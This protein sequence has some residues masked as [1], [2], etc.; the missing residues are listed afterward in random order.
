MLAVAMFFRTIM[1]A[2]SL[3]M[4][5]YV[6]RKFFNPLNTFKTAMWFVLVGYCIMREELSM[7]GHYL[8]LPLQI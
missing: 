5:K 6:G 4:M 2:I 7:E 3:I 1:F 8:S